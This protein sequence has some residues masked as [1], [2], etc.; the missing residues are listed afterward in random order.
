MHPL[1]EKFLT[2]TAANRL[3]SATTPARGPKIVTPDFATLRPGAGALTQSVL[4][5]AA[6]LFRLAHAFAAK[7]RAGGGAG[8]AS[9]SALAR[10]L[11]LRRLRGLGGRC[12]LRG[13]GLWLCRLEKCNQK[14]IDH[15]VAPFLPDRKEPIALQHQ[16]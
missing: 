1:R 13:D 16:E 4:H 15:V 10:I 6:L 12:A 9:S 11:G 14:K 5:G 2:R 8:S 3:L 7:P